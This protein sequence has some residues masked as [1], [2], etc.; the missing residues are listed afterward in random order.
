MRMIKYAADGLMILCG[1]VLA[2]L[3]LPAFAGF[4]IYTVISSSMSPQIPVGAVVYVSSRPFSEIE[5]GSV[6]TYRMEGTATAVTHRV[7]EKIE[8]ER[9]FYTKGDAN[10]GR[11]TRKV[12]YEEVLGEVRLSV[13]L[14]GY[15]A[16]LLDGAEK[17]LMAAFVL[18]WLGAVGVL[19]GDIVRI[20]RRADLS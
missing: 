13:P 16:L 17:K 20:R 15:A 19:A 8:E 2:V 1:V 9:A 4:Q 18:L 6:I 14:L 10:R 3:T 5:P 11:D 7:I 12:R